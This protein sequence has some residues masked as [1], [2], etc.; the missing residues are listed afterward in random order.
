MKIGVWITF[1]KSGKKLAWAGGLRKQGKK[2]AA[3]YQAGFPGRGVEYSKTR[4]I[5]AVSRR[6]AVTLTCSSSGCWG[7]ELTSLVLAAK[8]VAATV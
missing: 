7:S 5:F 3:E 6:F 8:S 4:I 2:C 1:G